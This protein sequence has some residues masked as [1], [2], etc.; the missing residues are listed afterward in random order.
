MTQCAP[1]FCH[2]VPA[3]VFPTCGE[4]PAKIALSRMVNSLKGVS[5]RR[6]RRE[7]PE[8]VRHIWHVQRL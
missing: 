8:L 2:Q 4:L 7:F 6:M 3:R 1:E 5:S